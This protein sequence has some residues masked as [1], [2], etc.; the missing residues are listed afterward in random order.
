MARVQGREK[1]QIM[2]K[3]IVWDGSVTLGLSLN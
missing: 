3:D 1:Y 2:T